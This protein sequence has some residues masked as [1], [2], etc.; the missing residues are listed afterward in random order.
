MAPLVFLTQCHCILF[1]WPFVLVFPYIL[2]YRERH[3]DTFYPGS[4]PV[5]PFS[6]LLA[7]RTSLTQTLPPLTGGWK[8][9]VNL[10]PPPKEMIQ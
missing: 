10:T 9:E 5:N 1:E 2:N 8:V 7:T 3:I 6:V 4:E